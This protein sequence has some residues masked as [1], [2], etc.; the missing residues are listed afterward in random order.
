MAPVI[1]GADGKKV[2]NRIQNVR[3]KLILPDHRILRAI[4]PQDFFVC[5]EIGGGGQ[6]CDLAAFV[7]REDLI[8]MDKIRENHGEIAFF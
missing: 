5:P 2:V 8:V 6:Q 7:F 1:A 3:M 4:V